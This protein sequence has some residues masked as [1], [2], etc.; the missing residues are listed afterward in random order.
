MS[1]LSSP[2]PDSSPLIAAFCRQ[3][4]AAQ[5]L[6][7]Q[8]QQEAEFIR[9]FRDTT[10]DLLLQLRADGTVLN[11]NHAPEFTLFPVTIEILQ[12]NIDELL[13][14]EPA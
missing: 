9:A 7:Y 6:E 14:T 5:I 1:I 3:L 10:P 13:P 4:H 12:R 8:F 2:S 11:V